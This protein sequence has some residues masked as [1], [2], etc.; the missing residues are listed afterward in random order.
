M[1]ASGMTL[2]RIEKILTHMHNAQ[3]KSRP[4]PAKKL[5]SFWD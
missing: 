3:S 5:T 2:I 1:Q 4:K